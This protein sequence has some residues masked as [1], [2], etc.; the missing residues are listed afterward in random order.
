MIF[1]FMEIEYN[2][3]MKDFFSNGI[4]WLFHRRSGNFLKEHKHQNHFHKYSKEPNHNLHSLHY[5][6]S[7]ESELIK[8]I[9]L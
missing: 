7:V 1:N 3:N 9:K 4:L 8:N 2:P 6:N 5:C